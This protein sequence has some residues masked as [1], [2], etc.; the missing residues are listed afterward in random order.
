MIPG[1]AKG[2]LDVFSA[3]FSCMDV[4]I[5]SAEG[6]ISPGLQFCQEKTT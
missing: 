3:M 1:L 6:W 4:G 2:P 5:G